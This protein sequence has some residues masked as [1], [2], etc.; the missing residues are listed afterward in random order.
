M[1]P[2]AMM[3]PLVPVAAPG[4]APAAAVTTPQVPVLAEEEIRTDPEEAGGAAAAVLTVPVVKAI[5]L[6]MVAVPQTVAVPALVHTEADPVVPA[7]VLQLAS[8]PPALTC[9]MVRMEPA[10]TGAACPPVLT[11]PGAEFPSAFASV[12]VPAFVAN[13]AVV[14]AVAEPA[15]PVVVLQMAVV[16]LEETRT[17]P[18]APGAVAPDTLTVL[19]ASCSAD[20]S[21]AVP[22]LVAKPEVVAV[23]ALVAKEAEP[24]VPS[25]LDHTAVPAAEE[26][27]TEPDAPGAVAAPMVTDPVASSKVPTAVTAAPAAPQVAVVPLLAISTCPEEG[28]AASETFTVP[29]V[30]SSASATVAVPDEAAPE[31]GDWIASAIT[32]PP[33]PASAPAARRH[34]R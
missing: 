10:A 31:N 5:A 12:A 16:A 14:A 27:R 34:P 28:A 17:D 32:A 29:V 3:F 18:A 8:V 4:G 13:P 26:T 24:Q 33:S 9:V 7:V 20:A 1:G 22:A 2:A 19:V 23:P 30:S 6:E 15:V 25:V 21:V 11:V